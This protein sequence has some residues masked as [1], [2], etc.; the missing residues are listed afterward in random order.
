M[1]VNGGLVQALGAFTVGNGPTTINLDGGL[2]QTPAW[3]GRSNSVALSFNG[4]TLQA[5]SS[6][7]N[8]LAATTSSSITVY[9]GGAVIDTN[10]NN[11]S[12]LQPLIGEADSGITSVN[13]GRKST[14]VFASPPAV[15]FTGGSGS[16]AT[17]Y[18][19]LSPSGTINGIVVTNPGN[20]TVIP[21]SI[22][23]TGA[24]GLGLTAGTTS[25]NIGGLMKNGAGILAL[26]GVNTYGGPTVIN[27][28]TLQLATQP[29]I[30]SGI[31]PV[32]LYPMNGPLGA[33]AAGAGVP[34]SVSG[35]NGTVNGTGASYV[36]GNFSQS[37]A[38][39]FSNSSYFTAPYSSALALSTFTYS[40]WVNFTSQ[41]PVSG[42]GPVLLSTRN[43][44]NETFD[45]QYAQPSAGNYYLHADIGTGSA[46]LNTAA[47]S[48]TFG[49]LSGWN[50]VTYV[51]NS[52]ADTYS[53]YLNGASVGGGTFS[54]TAL[55][56]TSGENLSIAH[57]EA[58][59]TS[60]NSSSG[61][62]NGAVEDAGIYNGAMTPAEVQSL[63]TTTVGTLPTA[64][65]VTL[66]H[67]ATFDLNGTTQQV[68]SLQDGAGGGGTLTN[69]SVASATLT[70]TPPSGTYTFSGTIT[71]GSIR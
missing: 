38:L 51:V 63:Y 2:L 29:G 18:A 43:G 54:G 65:P 11:I 13:I 3:M 57:Q 64:T 23:V 36:A 44:G 66:A 30:P 47:N 68:A 24:T 71:N 22:N 67:G 8:Y 41:P 52:M 27:A 37:Q 12:I 15:T 5:N 32:A 58:G 62:L 46:W 69:S 21:T 39:Q 31:Q 20:Y 61:Y 53:I 70:L 25:N 4:G 59:G 49:A 6:G 50:M 35:L 7:S 26:A 9:A 33:I 48:S 40:T 28:G 56:M 17:A 55:M 14:I 42:S 10:G 34:E 60:Y 19:T 1:N 45:L 16:G